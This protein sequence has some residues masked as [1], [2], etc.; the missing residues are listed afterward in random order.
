MARGW[1][2]SRQETNGSQ[3]QDRQEAGH[4]SSP[5][6]AQPTNANRPV[7][8]TYGGRVVG[9]A[10]LTR[11][12]LGSDHPD[13]FPHRT[14]SVI[15]ISTG[16]NSAHRPYSEAR[17]AHRCPTG[18]FCRESPDSPYLPRMVA[19]L[20]V[21]GDTDLDRDIAHP[22]YGFVGPFQQL[23]GTKFQFANVRFWL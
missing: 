2:G 19:R 3:C 1:L 13:L 22:S 14:G 18:R 15:E 6:H 20:V 4:A 11:R 5:A 23:G 9:A 17:T 16:G 10:N 8:V 12:R 21:Q 7:R